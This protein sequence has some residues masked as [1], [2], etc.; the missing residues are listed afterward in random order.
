MLK[1]FKKNNDEKLRLVLKAFEWL[2]KPALQ[3]HLEAQYKTGEIYQYGYDIPKDT[4]LA[5]KCIVI[6]I[7]WY[8]RAYKH[9]QM[10]TP[11]NLGI[12]YEI[13]DNVRDLQKAIDW[14]QKSANNNVEGNK[15]KKQ[16]N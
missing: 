10:Y 2:L 13:E 7:D 11:Y 8:T 14:Y 12:I 1:L 5:I 3:D 15:K 16:K 4:E 9:V 6:A